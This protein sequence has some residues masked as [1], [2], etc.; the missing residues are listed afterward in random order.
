M[1]F[2]IGQVVRSPKNQ[3]KA[4]VL[5][6]VSPPEIGTVYAVRL[7]SGHTNTPSLLAIVNLRGWEPT[8]ETFTGEG[9]AFLA[10]G[11]DGV[12]ELTHPQKEALN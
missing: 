6:Q 8:G 12:T 10:G 1:S 9:L 11:A 5:A 2:Q 4:V 7:L 3:W